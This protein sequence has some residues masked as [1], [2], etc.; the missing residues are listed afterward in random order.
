M[1][2]GW[3]L[4]PV[5]KGGPSKGMPDE[6][7]GIQARRT[8]RKGTLPKYDFLCPLIPPHPTLQPLI[9]KTHKKSRG[10]VTRPLAVLEDVC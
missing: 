4:P 1:I 5:V 6:E 3:L 9:I 7:G 10:W 8:K 2:H